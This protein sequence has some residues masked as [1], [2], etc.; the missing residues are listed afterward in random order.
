[1]PRRSP[2]GHARTL[3]GGDREFAVYIALAL[4]FALLPVQAGAP[5]AAH[6]TWQG[7]GSA[8]FGAVMAVNGIVI[9]LLQPTISSWIIGRD[10]TRLLV[11]ATLLFGGGL[12]LH[13]VAN[14][15]AVRAAAVMVWTL[16][17]IVESPTR[18]SVIAAMAPIHARGRYQGASVMTFGLAQL[19]GPKLG[20]WLWQH[21]GP[22]ALWASCLG[23]AILLAVGL[24][25]TGPA[26]RRRMARLP[27]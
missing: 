10:P 3:L 25:A 18:S 5:L 13:G 27:G 12:A 1:L 6:M 15:V 9:T 11:V 26:R 17:E 23:F 7:L 2:F 16:G 20:T 22:G 14:G 19:F 24:A 8:S 21:G 4:G